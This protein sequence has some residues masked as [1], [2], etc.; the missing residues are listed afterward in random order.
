[1]FFVFGKTFHSCQIFK[2]I[3]A[4]PST[5]WI[6]LVI[7]L[8]ETLATSL[9][10][11]GTAALDELTPLW[12]LDAAGRG[13]LLTAVQ[14]GFI[15]GTL[16]LSMTGLAD[17]FQASRVFAMSALL[18]ACANAGF[19]WFSSSWNEAILWRGLTGM[20]LAGIY[21]LGMK[22]VMTWMPN[23]AGEALGWLVG[24]VSLGT[25]M[26]FLLRALGG[27]G[28]WQTVV[29]LASI[30]ALTAGA[31]VWR[32][33][34]GP[35][36]RPA[37]RRFNFKAAVRSF[38]I[39]EFRSSASGYFGHMWELYS[40]WSMVPFL[41]GYCTQEPSTKAWLSFAVIAVGAV[42]NIWGGRLSR[43]WG[44][45]WVAIGALGLSGLMC[46]ACPLLSWL[47][48]WLVLL[49]LIV[50]GLAAPADSPQF[51]ALSAQAC[52]PEAVGSALSLQNAIGFS[53]T[54]ISIQGTAS[55][56]E[57]WQT[58]IGW[59]WLPGPLLGLW[60]MRRWARPPRDLKAGVT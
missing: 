15:V 54:V 19:A 26:P 50:W 46:L 27:I 29:S 47:P 34:D 45:G 2:F 18:G 11:A 35:A 1:M 38:Q 28:H 53:I 55:L 59:L 44:S 23:R 8:A 49:V 32:L 33:G 3:P 42:G 4:M 51:S 58:W 30:L 48:P 14:L 5:R 17:G 31:M 39:I 24:A 10:F 37:A 52:P 60:S 22:L 41:V 12:S 56:V 9:W 6:L 40:F 16:T 57:S 21:P 25:S 43:K 20:A 36:A 13:G 7:V